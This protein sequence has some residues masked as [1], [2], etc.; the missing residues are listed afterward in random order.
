MDVDTHGVWAGRHGPDA[1]LAPLAALAWLRR[2]PADVRTRHIVQVV[3]AHR[4]DMGDLAGNLRRWAAAAR[5]RGARV[6]LS[7][8]ATNL[9]VETAGAEIMRQETDAGAAQGVIHRVGAD[10]GVPVYDPLP[11]LLEHPTDLYFFDTMH[12]SRHGHAVIGDGLAEQIAAELLP[13][14]S[15][16]P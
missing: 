10:L 2:L 11:Q 3:L 7:V 14:P 15:P 6:L 16:A 13:S 4:Y 9:Y 1:T 5:S 12:L 8:E